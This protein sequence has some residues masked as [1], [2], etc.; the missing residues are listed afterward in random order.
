MSAMDIDDIL[1]E[2]DA[3]G[4]ARDASKDIQ[5]LT[6]AWVAERTAPEIMPFQ[7]AL[8]ERL[9]ER[10]RQQIE[11]VETETGNLDPTSNFRLILIQTELE[12]VKY[13]VRAYLRIRMHKIDKY[14]FHILSNASVRS[15]L[16]PSE[17]SY[18]KSHLALLNNHYLSSFLRN[19][20]EQ[21]RR[22]DDTAGGISM[23]E[24][25]DMDSAV[26]C[27]VV[28]NVQDAVVRIPGTD[29]E[30]EL[31]KDD[32]YVVRYSAVREFV[33]SGDVELI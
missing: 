9:T 24:E 10:I 14:S 23:V 20:P 16:A 13:L 12:R 7:A 27:R 6:T 28:R 5:N 15:R 31:A 22:L 18:L 21:L 19:F 32:V 25:P 1:Q 4:A 2:F 17:I 33:V 8:V 26:F 30:F 11:L 3:G 29:T